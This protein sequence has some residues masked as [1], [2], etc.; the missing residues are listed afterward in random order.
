MVTAARTISQVGMHMSVAFAVMYT[1]TGSLALGGVAAVVEP[2]CNVLLLPV[3]D[4]A[5]ERIRAKI[6]AR[7]ASRKAATGAMQ[8]A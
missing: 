7:A 6:E 1:F 4:K 3:H 2:I 8:K 5:W